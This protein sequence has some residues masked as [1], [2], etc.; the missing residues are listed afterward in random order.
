L[1]RSVLSS[2]PMY[3]ISFFPLPKGVRRKLDYFRSRFFGRETIT[4]RNI[5]L[6]NGIFCVNLRIK[7]DLES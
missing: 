1:I 6:S 5:D 2:L 7:G 4:K 3:M